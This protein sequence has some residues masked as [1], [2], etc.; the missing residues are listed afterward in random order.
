MQNKICQEWQM[1]KK[2]VS[3]VFIIILI[4][5]FFSLAIQQEIRLDA[6]IS[7]VY[8]YPRSAMVFREGETEL[9]EGRYRIIFDD[10]IDKFEEKTISV[11][12]GQKS[13]DLAR[14]MGVSIE[15]V[16]LEEIPTEKIRQLQDEIN[17]LEKEI[18]IVSSEKS[19]L[20]DKKEFLNSIIY[21]FQEQKMNGSAILQIPSSEQLENIYLFLDEK[22]KINYDQILNYDFQIEQNRAKI[23]LLQKQLQQISGEPRETKKVIAVDLEVYQGSHLSIILSYQLNEA[24]SWQPVYDV[25]ANI[26]ENS[27]ELLTYAL[28]R[29]TTG[30]D[31][32]D[33]YVSLSTARPTFS[34]QLPPIESWVL[35]P[36]QPDQRISKT[37]EMPMLYREE[38]DM[39]T[40]GSIGEQ[41]L[42]VPVEYMGTS[43]TFHIP[44]KVSIPSGS[45][46]EKILISKEEIAGEFNYK[47]YPRESS[48]MYFNVY[49][50]N[51]LEIPL[52]PGQVNIFLNGGFTGNTSIGYIPPGEDIDISLGIA[53]NIKVK[54]ELLK[55]FIDETLI[56]T[57]PSSKIVTKYEYK[58]TVENF[59]DTES[60]C[61]IFEN[62]PVPED[63]RIQINI[64]QVTKEPSVKN[65]KD[66]E[67]VWMWEFSL[68]PRERIEIDIIYSVVH[69]RDMQII[70]LP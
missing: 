59:Q 6:V 12:L 5:S 39:L 66:K 22:L 19:S 13:D 16:V 51:N 47:T 20:I 23:T 28:I 1:I 46:Q 31:W 34:G 52:L 11:E 9:D 30:V 10:I 33:V 29:Q 65:W 7:K 8:I 67:G 32:E 36:Y 61:H 58:I 49:V 64:D 57:I 37:I 63:D 54:R 26:K 62:I 50:E 42:L 15:T 43:V 41:E 38:S 24:I 27:I 40:A 17:Q 53:E 48:F 14:I 70:G 55:K 35:R 18:R 68:E 21:F 4:F 44:Q 2:I 25:R 69:P 60:L 56:A 3:L 45:N